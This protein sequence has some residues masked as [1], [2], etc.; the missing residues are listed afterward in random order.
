M[1]CSLRGSFDLASALRCGAQ[2]DAVDPAGRTALYMAA[3][4]GESMV[5]EW[6]LEHGASI[7]LMNVY[8]GRT[9]LHAACAAGEGKCALQLLSAG[10]SIN[11]RDC[12]GRTPSEVAASAGHLHVVR[13]L[14]GAQ[15]T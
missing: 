15:F 7:D 11:M 13:L 2:V 3:E 8:D 9:A 1:H 6:L 4:A 12:S 5:V 10:A 14:F